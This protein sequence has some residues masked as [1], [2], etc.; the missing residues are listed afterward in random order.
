MVWGSETMLWGI[1]C[2]KLRAGR[3]TANIIGQCLGSYSRP[4]G[5]RRTRGMKPMSRNHLPDPEILNSRL[6]EATS[7]VQLPS[8][9]DVS[10]AAYQAALDRA[11][12][13]KSEEKIRHVAAVF[14]ESHPHPLSKTP[15]K[16]CHKKEL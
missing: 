16:D 7:P 1:P 8:E 14:H 10:Q 3:A 6:L 12:G 2:G 15:M 5:L 9:A 4:R 13:L 11:E